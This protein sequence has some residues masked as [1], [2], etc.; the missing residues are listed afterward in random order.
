MLADADKETITRQSS[1]TYD[2]LIKCSEGELFGPGNAQLLRGGG[3]V[4]IPSTD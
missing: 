2:E 4:T 1:Y 3:V